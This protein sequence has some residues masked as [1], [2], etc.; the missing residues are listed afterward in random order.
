MGDFWGD[1]KKVAYFRMDGPA[2]NSD[3][4]AAANSFFCLKFFKKIV[5]G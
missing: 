3:R 4:S 1:G 5:D 2:G